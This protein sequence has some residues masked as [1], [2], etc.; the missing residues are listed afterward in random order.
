MPSISI[1][2]SLALTLLHVVEFSRYDCALFSKL[3]LI[4]EATHFL[5]RQACLQTMKIGVFHT[6]PSSE[7]RSDGGGNITPIGIG[8]ELAL[9]QKP[10]KIAVF[11]ALTQDHGC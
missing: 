5:N 11:E 3:L 1:L 2:K 4:T 9:G 7:V 8:V 6:R 10:L